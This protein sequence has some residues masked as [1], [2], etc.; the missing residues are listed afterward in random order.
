MLERERENTR[1]G[2]VPIGWA[3]EMQG[4]QN[5]GRQAITCCHGKERSLGGHGQP[6]GAYR[7]RMRILRQYTT[8]NDTLISASRTS[9]QLKRLM[10]P[11]ACG[12]RSAAAWSAAIA[13]S[14]EGRV[15]R[16][17]KT[18]LGL[19]AAGAGLTRLGPRKQPA[20]VLP[21]S[22][23]FACA[24]TVASVQPRMTRT[25]RP[26]AHVEGPL[27]VWRAGHVKSNARAAQLHARGCS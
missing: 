5:A 15:R 21:A 22:L 1:E 19:R 9:A 2:C 12:P 26:R 11:R 10:L 8:G 17:R 3:V 20:Q 6:S 24:A 27:A 16:V 18:R 25:C 14:A 7:W 23:T 13:C 4:L